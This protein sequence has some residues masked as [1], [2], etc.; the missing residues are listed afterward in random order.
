MY[1]GQWCHNLLQSRHLGSS[2]S[3][4]NHHKLPCCIFLNLADGSEVSSLSKVILVSGKSRSCR[5][6]GFW[7]TWVIW[8]FAKTLYTRHDEWAGTLSRWRCQS[9]VV[10]SCC[11][12]N[13]LNSFCREIF[14]LNAKLDADS[15]LYLP[16][17]FECDGHTVHMLTQWHLLSPLTSTVR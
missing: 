2:Q 14:K 15:L 12:L 9:P 1:T 4:P 8:Y 3:F 16:N 17:Y 11:L 10:H 13:H 5:A 6:I 7:V